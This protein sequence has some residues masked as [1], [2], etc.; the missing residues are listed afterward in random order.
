MSNIYN[1]RKK[2]IAIFISILFILLNTS[3]NKNIT[4][5]TASKAIIV[6]P[7]PPEPPKFQFL[8]RITTSKDIGSQ[9]NGFSKLVLGEERAKAFVKPYGMALHNGKMYV[10]DNYGGG[11]EIIDFAKNKFDFFQPEGYGKLRVPINCIVDDN[12]DL[13]VADMGRKDIAV[14]DSTG[15]FLKSFG[16]KEQFKPSDVL[17]NGDTIFVSNLATG[18]ILAYSKDATN[19]LLYTFPKDEDISASMGLPVNLAK[20]NNNI[21]AADFGYSQIKVFSSEG[22]LVDSVGRRGD[23]PGTFAKLKG[24]AVDREGIV[25][26]VDAAFENVQVFN[27]EGKLLIAIGG[28][29]GGPGGLMMPAKVVIDYDHLD[30]FKQYVDPSLDLKYLIFVTSQYGPDLINVYGRVEPKSNNK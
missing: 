15:K 7:S 18:K 5:S 16:E 10:C 30:Y 22:T 26:A 9:Q 8:K 14:F 1:S 19:K 27:P 2:T 17:I 4:K 25:Y 13:Y 3:C 6:Y 20:Y 23:A 12:G 29:Y 28:H 11:M 21:Y 24:I